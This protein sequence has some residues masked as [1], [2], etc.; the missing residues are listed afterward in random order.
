M[1]DNKNDFGRME[2]QQTFLR[3]A[4]TAILDEL[5][6][7]PLIL[8]DLLW[9]AGEL[10]TVDPGLDVADAAGSMRAAFQD[11]LLSF[12]LPAEQ[13]WHGDQN[14]LDLLEDEATPILAYFRGEGPMPP[15]PTPDTDLES[16]VRMKALILAGGEGTRLRPITHT[17]AKQLVPVANKPILFYGIE[18]MVEAGIT[19][20]GVITGS[21]GPEVMAAIGDGSQ[22]GAQV[23]YIPQEA[24]L[25]LAHCVLIA[26]DFLGDDDFVMYLGDNLLEQDLAAFVSAFED[27]RASDRPPAAQILLKRVPDPHRFGIATL[28]ADGHV[29]ELVE[30]PVDPPSDLALVGVYLFDRG[31]HEAVRAIEP[32]PRGELEITDAIQWLITNGRSVRTELLTGWWIDTGKLTPLLEANRLL[33]EKI[34]TRIDGK[35]DADSSVEGRVIVAD[36]RGGGELDD[37]G[38]RSR[39]AGT[40]A[41]STASSGRSRRSATA[42]RWSTARSSIRW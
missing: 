33:L 34:D 11:G 27:A 39:S 12:S 18:A 14:A 19:E 3:T 9:A 8:G 7:N 10:V 29:I 17:R 35:V 42:A 15:D 23:T 13:A 32:S 2:R 22:F 4:A 1:A 41:S 5:K 40:R 20:I 6:S 16:R 21:T 37:P 26:R 36:G 30:K 38:S 24:P 31:I 25:G 28:D